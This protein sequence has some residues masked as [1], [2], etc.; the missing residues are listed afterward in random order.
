MMTSI[1]WCLAGVRDDNSYWCV[2]KDT[3]SFFKGL[4]FC[5]RYIFPDNT[6]DFIHLA[7]HWKPSPCQGSSSYA[8]PPPVSAFFI[9]TPAVGTWRGDSF[10]VKPEEKDLVQSASVSPATLRGWPSRR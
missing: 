5:N 2:L 8:A 10:L 3:K 6:F 4:A 1:L 7:A 9:L